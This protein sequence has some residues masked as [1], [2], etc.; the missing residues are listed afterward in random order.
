MIDL[1]EGWQL[2]EAPAGA[3]ARALTALP[4]EAWLPAAV[5]GTAH[6]A[7][8][9]AGRI[10]DP[11]YGM[12][13][14]EVRWV[15]ERRWAWRLAFEAGEL[16]DH[17]DLVFE[18][19]DTWCRAWLNG[20]RLL[21]SDNMFVP[22]RVDVRRRLQPGRNELLLCFEPALARAR[23][24]EAVHGKR[25]LWNGDSARLHA[26]KAQYH[27]G[28]DWGP[29][30]LVSGPW[31]AVRRH[32][33]SARIDDLH[34]RSEVD[35]AG[36]RAALQVSARA[37]GGSGLRCAFELLDTEGRSVALQSV[38][39]DAA[40]A[41]LN[42]SEA[43]LWWPRGLGEQPLYTLVARL[44]DGERVVAEDSRRIGLRTL[45]LVQASVEGEAGSSF[46]FEVNGQDF[47][48]GGANWIPDD[49]L[50]E[51][52]TPARYRERVAQAADA[53]MNMLRVWGGGIYEDEAFYEACDELGLL[54]W[55]DFM[56]ACGLYPANADFLASVRAEA[57]SQVKRLR[58]HACMALWCGNNEDYML[59]ESVGLA[60]P[61]VP[62]ERFEARAIYEGL[63]PEVCE[64]LDPATPYW[65]GSPFSPGDG[66][67]SSDVTVGD[68][69]SWEVWHQ[70]MLP[71]Q[72]Y[73]DV[74]ARFVSEF[75]MQS[76]PSLALFESVL[77][78][79]ERFPESRTVQWHNKAGSAA[80][81][82]GHR[83][84]SV[85]L[86]DNLRVGPTLAD[87]V[88]ATQFVQAEAMR[89]AYQDFRRSWQRPGARAVGGALVWQL[90]DC[91]P[92]TSW[93][94]ID[95]SGTV[96]PAWH[97]V[98]RALA[99]LA[100]AVRLEAGAA[101]LAIM[102]GQAETCEL[103][104]QLRV[105]A[106]DGRQLVSARVLQAVPASTS[107][108]TTQ[109]LPAFDEPVVAE[110]SALDPQDGREL[111][112]D[113]AWTEPF[114]F[115][116]LAGARLVIEA[117]GQTLRLRAD[118]PVKGLWLQQ[119]GLADN[120]IDL[121]PGSERRIASRIALPNALDLIGLELP[122]QQIQLLRKEG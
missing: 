20:E 7:L 80:G 105:F 72:R 18:G 53:N 54:V 43:Q 62:A 87:H 37:T 106:M 122:A 120:F 68:R 84:L 77:P 82:D 83:R 56:F 26:R 45:R 16:A 66:A 116:R 27:F 88:Y 55:Q 111:A 91:W 86:A 90:N 73:G 101:R 38:P 107:V 97:A 17:E 31:R 74:Q 76:H 92:V 102:N 51:R 118:R 34:C 5:P 23:E 24:V 14:A 57:E 3:D 42:V 98:R 95:S 109:P 117:E 104:L 49:N 100:V 63:L 28:W 30:L 93:A 60:G 47:F 81:P 71:Y 9:A 52:I 75:G 67:K 108:E 113:C 85:Y 13:E 69:H 89:V 112:R 46:H 6:G 12:N 32:S 8:L 99:P 70:Q 48:A 15:G 94:L 19:L 35:V 40:R 58:H 103:A 29:E 96:K 79:A 65:P 44:L 115:Y 2:A 4:D 1:H 78:A 33:W 10:P 59:A 22:H 64:A 119:P 41:T 11:F 121:V 110:L 114:K 61:G 36:R 50:L 25:Q 39:A 21:E